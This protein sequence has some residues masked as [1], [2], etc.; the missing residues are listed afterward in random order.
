MTQANVSS[1]SL[2]LDEHRPQDRRVAMATLVGTSI[3][4]YDYFI[5]AN[6]AALIFGKQFF[7]AVP[8]NMQLI[9][10]F[11]TVGISFLF[12]P[13]GA[14]VAG[15]YGD[16]VGR[17]AM[18]VITLLLMGGATALIGVLPTAQTIGLWAP[19][20]LIVLR[21]V[22]GFSA[23]GEWGGAALMAVE[24]APAS[25]RGKFGAFPQIGV[26]VGMLIATG[27]LAML[28]VLLTDA[29]FKTWGWRI[30]FLASAVLIIIGMWIRLGVTESPVFKELNEHPDEVKMP[31][32][33]VFRFTGKQVAQAALMFMG[34]GVAGYMVTGGFLLAYTTTHLGMPKPAILNLVTLASACWIVTTF[35]AGSLSDRFTR[36]RTYRVGYVA[37][38]LWVFPMFLLVQ[39]GQLVWVAVAM[40]LLTVPLG[41]TYGPQAALFA[42]MF[43]ASI[44]YSG[45]SI[46]YAL[47]S[48]LGG[49]FA[50][51]IAQALTDS[52][53]TVMSV[54]V[55][56]FV[57]TLI[58][59]VVTFTVKD[60]TGQ[61]IDHGAMDIPG[62][63]EIARLSASAKG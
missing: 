63:R 9:L 1:H 43:P 52:T 39:T 30:P 15:H 20:L 56:L 29:Q 47:G 33:Q 22:Q 14:A 13:L 26:P 2:V 6:A 32:G 3:E 49:A 51:M 54:P 41:L 59:L 27:F 38:L 31:L 24:H 55:Y 16:R 61:P 45:A 18:L 48:I 42:E 8:D 53:H 35:L 36:I 4:W 11:A 44:R 37:Q 40:V 17:K 57:V 7:S 50:P 23:G 46:S 25:K 19:V 12:R 58:A 62:A 21:I 34:N 5:Y 60:R 10:S 28:S